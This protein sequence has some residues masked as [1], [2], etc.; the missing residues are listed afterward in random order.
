MMLRER[1]CKMVTKPRALGIF[2]VL[3]IP[4]WHCLLKGPEWDSGRQ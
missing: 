3:P 4:P 2:P 1:V